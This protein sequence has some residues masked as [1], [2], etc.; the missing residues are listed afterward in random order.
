MESVKFTFDDDFS[1]DQTGGSYSNKMQKVNDDAFAEGKEQGLSEALQSIEKNCETILTEVS[2][3]LALMI[4][5]HEEQVASM[6]KNATSLVLAIVK[7]L[8]PAIVNERPLSEIEHLVQECLRNNP[9]EPRIVIRVDEQML[10]QLRKKIDS[11]QTTSDYSGQ[12]V[13]ISDTM[14]NLSDCRIEWIDG[15]AERDFEALMTTI[16]EKIEIF[17]NAPTEQEIEHSNPSHVS[18]EIGNVE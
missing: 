2:S 9:L 14:S 18:P 4:S 17:I 1:S 5:R 6:E 3:S 10:P 13:L 8:A 7:K 16:E 15:G 11:I 12:I